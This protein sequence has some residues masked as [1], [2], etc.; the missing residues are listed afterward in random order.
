MRCR[1]RCP[2]FFG[3]VVLL[4]TASDVSAHEGPPFPILM[5]QPTEGYVVSVWA[6]P[7]IG[8][9]LFYVIVESPEGGPPAKAPTVSM[10]AE[11]VNGRLGRVTCDMKRQKL[12]NQL[13][14][15]ARP[16]FDQRD[17]WTVG[18]TV[19]APGG[20]TGELTTEV[21][22]TPP[23]YGPWDLV[24]YLFPFVL[25]GGLWAVAMIRRYRAQKFVSH[26]E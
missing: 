5:D 19:V 10:W 4:A 7:D 9:A 15:E 24:V 3:L 6:D 20:G 2:L 11:P 13:Q 18:F 25:L 26:C 12:R 16:Y 17:M 8:E 1:H 21:E 14:F 22:S 23:G